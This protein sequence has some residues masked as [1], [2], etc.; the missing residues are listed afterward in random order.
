MKTKT[1]IIVGGGL[2]G[3]L[4]ATSLQ[5]QCKVTLFTKKK[6]TDCN[7][8]LAQGG[9]AVAMSPD[10]DW[11]SHYQDTLKA[12][13]FHND[14]AATSLLVKNGVTAI[15]K[16][17]QQGMA[18]D[19]D[20]QGNW[21]FGLEGAHSFPRILHCHG[22][23]TG[24][25]LTRFAHEHLSQVEIKEN[26]PVT[27]LLLGEGR[28]IGVEYLSETREPTQLYGD[29]V[30][31]ATGGIGGLY[32]LTTND[33]TI[34]GD[35]AALAIR[36]GV[37]L[38]DM[39]FVQF[40]PTLL[41]QDG[42]CY[43]LISEAVRGAGAHLVDEHGRLV[44]KEVHPMQDLAP[45]DIVARALTAEYQAGH[46]IF[47]DLREVQNFETHFP[48]ITQLIDRHQIPFRQ[49]N[50]IPVRPGAHFM[51]G[52]IATDQTG[53]TSLP[54]LYAVG[55]ATCTGVHGANRLASNS[56][57]EC[58]VFSHQ[59]AQEI[60]DLPDETK[61]TTPISQKLA[62]KFTLPDKATLQTRA[63]AALG[64]QRSPTEI[65]G[66][67]TWLAQF[68]FQSLPA[69]YSLTELETA[70]LCLVAEA[71]AQAALARKENLG[72]HAWRKN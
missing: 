47:L 36:A 27:R 29:A 17:I 63:W 16:M 31:L 12:G 45:R 70:N 71:I 52:G 34:T 72:A 18:F 26:Q 32:P 67:L 59:V 30:I 38:A 60:A 13:V 2:A 28:C 4:T 10:D 68:D 48:Q 65:E 20:E 57:L 19:Q 6:L 9:I 64:I 61:T 42:K 50:L 24:K 58:V 25:Y 37:R 5:E 49:N 54:G 33:E 7:S 69:H 66:F 46:Q 14:P 51:M 15:E 43:G 21:Q 1:V 56:L 40:H 44:M 23:Q 55:E 35:G 53:A 22:D 39:E 11:R 3:S 8:I 62:D 41:T